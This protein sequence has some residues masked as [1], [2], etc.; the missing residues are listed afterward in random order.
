MDSATLVTPLEELHDDVKTADDSVLMRIPHKAD[1]HA[2]HHLISE[3]PPLD[4]NSVYTYLL[5]SEHFSRTCLL[6]QTGDRAQGFVSA[7]VPPARPNVLFVWQVAVHQ[8]VRG[9]GLGPRMLK[10]LLKRPNLHAIEYIETTVGPDNEASRRMFK[11]LARG[12]D[13][14]VR[15]APLF[16]RSLFG[17][18][19]HDDEPLLSIGPIGA[20]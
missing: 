18:H 20:L 2:I 13:A 14:P 3:S 6:A 4:L 16:G 11:K 1:A 17:S 10:N 5:L 19:G 12:L 15:E 8:R 7:Y 9:T